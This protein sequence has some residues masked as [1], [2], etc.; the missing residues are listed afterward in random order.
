VAKDAAILAATASA[1][2]AASLARDPS[3]DAV[4]VASKVIATLAAIEAA[5]RETKEIATP[6]EEEIVLPSKHVT[7]RVRGATAIWHYNLI[8][9]L[10]KAGSAAAVR[11]ILSEELQSRYFPWETTKTADNSQ[12][13]PAEKPRASPDG[14]Q[15]E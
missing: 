8:A 11:D 3:A 15:N 4:E 9:K 6:K 2:V 1:Q 7:V 13:R 12:G 10:R 5:T 14:A